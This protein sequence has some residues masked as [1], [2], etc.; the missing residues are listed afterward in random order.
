MWIS[1]WKFSHRHHAKPTEIIYADNYNF[2]SDNN[3]PFKVLEK[4][5][6]CLKC[7]IFN[8]LVTKENTEKPLSKENEVKY[9]SRDGKKR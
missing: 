9:K 5:L 3:L 6:E 1:I 2:L 7:S 8:V 4:M